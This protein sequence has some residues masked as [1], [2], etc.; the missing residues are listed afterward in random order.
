MGGDSKM[1]ETFMF[2]VPMM[3]LK[4]CLL[5]CVCLSDNFGLKSVGVGR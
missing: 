1:R 2:D 5:I 3:A 4:W